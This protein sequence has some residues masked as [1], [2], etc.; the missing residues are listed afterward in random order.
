MQ[1]LPSQH[2]FK[3][4]RVHCIIIRID[5]VLQACGTGSVQDSKAPLPS[6]PSKEMLK[7]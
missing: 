6:K 2:A 7:P 3:L 5:A 1:Y 4:H